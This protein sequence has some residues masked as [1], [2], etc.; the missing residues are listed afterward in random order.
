MQDLK[1]TDF[2]RFMTMGESMMKLLKLLD[3]YGAK[4]V[5]QEKLDRILETFETL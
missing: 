5:N 4:E 1:K 2:E 3:Y